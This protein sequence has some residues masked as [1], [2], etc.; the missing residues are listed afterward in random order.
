MSGLQI[1]V[2]CSY[3]PWAE[4]AHERPA[5]TTE[6][7]PIPHQRDSHISGGNISPRNSWSIGERS[8]SLLH[9]VYGC[10]VATDSDK[11]LGS[12]LEREYRTIRLSPSQT[13]NGPSNCNWEIQES[14]DNV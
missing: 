10:G 1:L 12:L 6:P 2:C 8:S 9:D 13:R 4:D 11:K 3:T 14:N 5:K 7:I